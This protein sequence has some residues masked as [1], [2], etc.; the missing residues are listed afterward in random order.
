MD[1]FEQNRKQA[2][3]TWRLPL[4]HIG[5]HCILEFILNQQPNSCRSWDQIQ[6]AIPQDPSHERRHHHLQ[7][8]RNIQA[9][10]GLQTS[11]I[12]RSSSSP[13]G[14]RVQAIMSW[15]QLAWSGFIS[16]FTAHLRQSD[17]ISIIFPDQ[18]S[19]QYLGNIH[20]RHAPRTL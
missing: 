20:H 19:H 9:S 17:W 4:D 6:M 1:L 12:H 3:A 5:C 13:L 15:G 2:F 7:A 18:R 11:C 8:D 16:L 10:T 14:V